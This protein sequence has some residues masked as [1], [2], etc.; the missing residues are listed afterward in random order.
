MEK[1]GGTRYNSYWDFMT[2]FIV[3]FTIACSSIPCFLVGGIIPVIISIVI[4]L[5]VIIA[6]FGIY[7]KIVGD[8]L[9][10]YDFFRPKVYPIDKIAEIKPTKSILSAPATSI[11]RRLAIKFTDKTIHDNSTP[12]IISPVHQ[13]KFIRQLL[14][15]NP[16]III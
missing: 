10:I 9:I 16:N 7:Y 3:T 15:V 8:K 6:L 11:S 13:Q 4:P 14:S 1:L 5:F 12:L 2:W